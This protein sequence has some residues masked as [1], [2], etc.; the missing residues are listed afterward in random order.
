MQLENKVAFITG[1]GS[2]RGRAT[3]TTVIAEGGKVMIYD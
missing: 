1:G 3:A 2:G